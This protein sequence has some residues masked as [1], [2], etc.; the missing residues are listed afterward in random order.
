MASSLRRPVVPAQAA[1]VAQVAMVGEVSAALA[2]TAVPAAASEPLIQRTTTRPALAAAAGMAVA[3][4]Q[5]AAVPV[6]VQAWAAIRARST[7]PRAIS[8]TARSSPKP[9]ALAQA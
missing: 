5:Q 6:A 9:A 8:T 2:A 3:P 1:P 4:T 7:S